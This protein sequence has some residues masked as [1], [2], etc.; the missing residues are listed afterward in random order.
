MRFNWLKIYTLQEKH[1]IWFT[2]QQYDSV[3]CSY[4]KIYVSYAA[5]EYFCLFLTVGGAINSQCAVHPVVLLSQVGET[6]VLPIKLFICVVYYSVSMHYYYS[7]P[8]VKI[9][10]LKAVGAILRL[11]RMILL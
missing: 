4:K 3:Q 2:C 7:T 5:V 6:R 8:Y 10:F 9:A 1:T 11:L